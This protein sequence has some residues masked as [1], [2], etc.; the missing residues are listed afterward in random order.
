M[1]VGAPSYSGQ[2]PAPQLDFT[3][4]WLACNPLLFIV[5]M[6]SKRRHYG[7]VDRCISFFLVGAGSWRQL[8]R[9]TLSIL[10]YIIYIYIY[11]Y[12]YIDI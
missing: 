3:E 9:P 8:V 5:S 12:I 11:I 4:E 7:I 2:G 6:A 1:Y 10:S